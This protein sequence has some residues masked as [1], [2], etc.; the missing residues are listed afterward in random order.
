MKGRW[1]SMQEVCHPRWGYCQD[2]LHFRN[3][4]VTDLF[5]AGLFSVVALA[6]GAGAL[7]LLLSAPLL[8]AAI[9]LVPVSV[10]ALG[11]GAITFFRLIGTVE[12]RR[13]EPASKEDQ[14]P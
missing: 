4:Q 5:I 1:F 11:Y 13:K 7:Q 12:V 8:L 14:T 6:L 2:R 10:A 3:E 9:V